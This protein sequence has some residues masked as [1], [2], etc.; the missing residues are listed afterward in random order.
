MTNY[1]ERHKK[2]ALPCVRI[3]ANKAGG[4]GTS[5][6]SRYGSTFVLT[7]YHV[8]ESCISIEK[9]WS[10]LLKSERK[11]DVFEQVNV[12]FF[13]YQYSSR[14]IGGTTI[15]SDIVCY[16]PDEDLALIRLRTEKEMP[17]ADL[18]PRDQEDQ[19]R[20]GM[21]IICVGAGLG[22][23]PVQTGGFLSQFGQEIDRKEYWLGTA[24]MIFGNSG[25]ALF[26]E[27]TYELIGVPS[28][29]SVLMLGW[30]IDPITHLSYSVP[31]TRI[32]QFLEDQRFRFIYDDNFT[33]EGEA[34]TRMKLR[35]AEER[36]SS[37][38]SLDAEDIAE[39]LGLD[40]EDLADQDL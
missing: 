18:Y 2:I 22:K 36:K 3:R 6:Y 24:P 1:E 31:I 29:I 40:D 14:S 7:N 12:H 13:E 27:E 35:K 4:S 8:I 33:E 26:L 10:A 30:S 39:A 25:G 19:L 28:Q 11:V 23:P 9:K 37:N 38:A 16:D 34:E 15:Q 32:Y 21:P 5:V 20:V 17:V